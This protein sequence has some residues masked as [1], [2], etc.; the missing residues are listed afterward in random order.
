MRVAHVNHT[1]GQHGSSG[2]EQSVP[3]TCA[4][5]EA[6]GVATCVLYDQATGPPSATPGRAI[7]HIP[8]LCGFSLL[9]RQAAVARALAILDAA[10]VDVVHLHQVNN[11]PLVT[12]IAA[13]WPT[14]YFVHNHILT[15][16]SGT[17]LLMNSGQLCPQPG[18]A[19][20]CI[21]NAYHQRCN[22]RRPGTVL[23]TLLRCLSARAFAHGLALGVDSHYMKAT[24]VAS[25]YPADAITVTPTVTEI[26]P[27]PDGYYPTAAPPRI[28][29]VGQLTE[30]KG[31]PLLLEALRRLTIPANLVVA[32]EGYLLPKLR[33]QVA[34]LGLQARVTFAGHVSRQRLSELLRESAL[35]AVPARYP[36][37]FGLVGPEAM[38]HA[39]PVV[40]FAT[41]GIP[42]WLDD[43]VTGL[44]ARPNDVDDF[45]AKIERLL[46]RPAEARAMGLAGREAWER[47]FH[48]HHH[49]ATLLEV[50]DSLAASRPASGPATLVAR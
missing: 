32:G 36:E 2:T 10:S 37:P 50:Y 43:G 25:G 44:L 26:T 40:A 8:G 5:L 46:A 15:C 9:P 18:P 41:G 23:Y 48:P 28:L 13:R 7:H 11:G 33:Q 16:P 4:L 42:E 1:Y 34:Q 35:V 38:A 39:R 20:S 19:P 22:S 21:A 24:L 6:R 27:P 12:A 3:N 31:A 17:R 30:I 47:R 49:V 45:A 29:Y 14:F